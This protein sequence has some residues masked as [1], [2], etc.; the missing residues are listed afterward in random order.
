M[1]LI[2]VGKDGST[3]VHED[4]PL[5]ITP[6]SAELRAKMRSIIDSPEEAVL[7][8]EMNRK[9][10]MDAAILAPMPVGGEDAYIAAQKK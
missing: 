6:L 10:L 2:K 5:I 4:P 1:K 3:T 8:E 9:R 7:I